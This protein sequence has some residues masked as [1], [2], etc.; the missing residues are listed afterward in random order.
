MRESLLYIDGQWTG[1]SDGQ[2]FDIVNPSTEEVI[3]KGAWASK[4]DL[5]SALAA[6]LKGFHAWRSVSPYDRSRLMR[7]AVAVLESRREDIARIMTLEQGKTLAEASGEMGVCI[8]NLEWM[9][10]EA[11]R[12]YG[13]V[14]PERTANLRQHM[15][16]QPIGPVA[17]FSPWNFPAQTPGRKIGGALAAGCSIILKPSEETPMTAAE[18]VRAFHDAGLPPGVLNLVHGHPAEISEH[19]IK[20]PIIRKISFTGSTA[21]GKGLLHL[22][23]DGVK[24]ATMELG[25]HSPVVVFDDVDPVS[26]AKQAVAAKMRNAGQV[27]TSPTRFYVQDGIYK[28][29]RD[30]F[31]EEARA[32]RIGDGMDPSTQ[33]GPLANARRVAAMQA[34]VEDA[35][36]R[37]AKLL[38]G[39]KRI[40][41]PGYYFEFTV[42]ED[43]PRNAKMK[44]E[45]PFGP[46]ASIERFNDFEQVCRNANDTPYGLAAYALTD[47]ASRAAAISEAFE[48]GVVAINNYSVSTPASPLGGVKD[49]GYGFEGGMEGL[50]AYLIS[51]SVM[52][53]LAGP[54]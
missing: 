14:L 17:A 21:V 50:D 54:L 24:R 35:L 6:A 41:R 42:L 2:T 3:A 11:T 30:A 27:C 20:S 51:K 38:C 19:L 8:A 28:E 47:S 45:E 29:F 12:G 5:D 26:A 34:M 44:A 9:A 43:V 7:K 15:I 18:I 31:V 48:A 32:I 33:M 39:G 36:D 49:S 23:A 1:S 25:G 13:R 53:K 37:H 4:K 22:A 16:K 40:D 10:E 46:M 52:H